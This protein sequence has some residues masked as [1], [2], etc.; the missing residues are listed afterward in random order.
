M[1]QFPITSISIGVVIADHDRFKN[2]LEIGE[3]EAGVKHLAKS[4]FG[5]TYV[6]D[7]RKQ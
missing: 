1:E 6:I 5:S 2:I 7:R 3:V 4:I